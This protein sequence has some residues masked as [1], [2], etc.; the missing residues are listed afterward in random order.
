MKN[1]LVIVIL[2]I[3][4]SS[5]MVHAHRVH[6]TTRVGEIKVKAWFG[7]GEPIRDG[8]VRVYVLQDGGEE[9]YVEGTTDDEGEY[10]FPHKIGVT[11]YRVEIECTHMPGHRAETVLNMTSAQSEVMGGEL[12]TEL[13]PY[14]GVIAGVGYLIG[15]AG[16]TM[17]YLSRRRNA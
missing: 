9:L 1:V 3:V 17:I 13:P 4:F 8:D 14:Q 6:V 15:L 16:F 2:F 5:G 12:C 7:G 11:A 10:S